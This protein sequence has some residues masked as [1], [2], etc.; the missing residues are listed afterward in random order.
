[1]KKVL[2]AAA[3]ALLLAASTPA[4]AW[5]G[6]LHWENIIGII[7]AGNTVGGV[8]GGGEPW[9]TLGGE[10]SVDPITSMVEFEVR[11]LVLAG[12]NAIG[13]TGGITQIQGTL[14]CGL[15]GTPIV[16]NTQPVM[17]SALGDAEFS[18]PFAGSTATCTAASGV[19]FLLTVVANDHWIANGSVLLAP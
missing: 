3:G 14:V 17:L 7:Q 15:T 4:P 2:G 10:V 19:A 11:G 9:S 12:G 16:I 1:M 8:V 5:T 6:G 18:G 13:T